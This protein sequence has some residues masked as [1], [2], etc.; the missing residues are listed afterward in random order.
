MGHAN[1]D[2]THVVYGKSWWEERVD[3]VTQAVEA[4]TM[5]LK[6]PRKKRKTISLNGRRKCLLI[7]CAGAQPAILSG[8]SIELRFI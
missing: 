1:T 7:W 6:I 5:P 3:A 8:L 2:L 4:V